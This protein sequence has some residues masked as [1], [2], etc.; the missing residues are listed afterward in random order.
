MT[1]INIV[2]PTFNEEDN[3]ERLIKSIQKKLPNCYILIVDD[4]K[5]HNIELI[6]KKNIKKK[7]DTLIE[8]IPKDAELSGALDLAPRIIGVQTKYYKYY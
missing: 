3:I 5:N 4:S 7:Q 2:I 6:L 1:E 8:K